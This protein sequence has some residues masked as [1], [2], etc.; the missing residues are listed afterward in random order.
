MSF[1]NTNQTGIET[2]RADFLPVTV[3]L[4]SRYRERRSL[5]ASFSACIVPSFDSLKIVA[6]FTCGIARR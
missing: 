5:R 1:S 2:L 4:I 3:I 6:G